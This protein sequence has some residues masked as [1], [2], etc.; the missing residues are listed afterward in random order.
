MKAFI[1]LH[2]NWQDTN[3]TLGN[4]TVLD[5][6]NKP[7]FSGLSLER[8]WRNNQNNIS[9]IPA[10][11]YTVKLE[12]S[13]RFKKKLWEIKNVPGRAETKFH[14]ANYWFQLNGC[15]ALGQRLADL[16][17]DGYQDITNSVKTMQAFHKA[18]ENFQEAVL[19]ITT[20]PN[21]K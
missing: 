11:V 12:Y 2:R 7:V 9:C 16:N 8:G 14:S 5:N 20:E 6:A 18:L 13:N 10:G 3:Q 4:C 15:V 21:V 1:K 19:I 17:K